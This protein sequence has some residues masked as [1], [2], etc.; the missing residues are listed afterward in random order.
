MSNRTAPATKWLAITNSDT[1]GLLA[2]AR[3]LYIVTG[4][5]LVIEDVNANT[6]T[7]PV[8][9]GQILPV[10]P[11]RVFATGSTATCLALY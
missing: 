8:S 9:A 1:A 7:F 10:S 4:G 3:S 5:N 6:E 2:D 11:V